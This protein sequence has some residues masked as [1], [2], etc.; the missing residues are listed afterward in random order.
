MQLISQKQRKQRL[1]K[2]NEK[3]RELFSELTNKYP[4]WRIDAVIEEVAGRVFLSPRT[5]EAI[6]SF[7][8]IYA[9]S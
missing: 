1:Q 8:G 2:R 5:V 4:Q 9:E 7:E 6:L 3:I